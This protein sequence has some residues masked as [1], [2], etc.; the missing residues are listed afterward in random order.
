M[1]PGSTSNI[2]IPESQL[3]FPKGNA[4]KIVSFFTET[5]E[6]TETDENGEYP[7]THNDGVLSVAREL[8][9]NVTLSKLKIKTLVLLPQLTL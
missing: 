7:E 2:S 9:E 4:G 8:P 5:N 6:S 1:S 3:N